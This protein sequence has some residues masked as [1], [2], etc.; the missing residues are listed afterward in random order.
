MKRRGIRS[1]LAWFL[2]VALLLSIVPMAVYA[3]EEPALRSL[4]E[5]KTGT[6]TEEETEALIKAVV[7]QLTLTEKVDLLGGT[8]GNAN[9]G[10]RIKNTGAAGGTYTSARLKEMGI[11]PLTLSDGPAG[12]RM[13]YKA[14][15][16]TSPTA[17]ASTWDKQAMHDIAV[18]TGKEAVFYGIDLMLAPGQNILR[19]PVAG[20]NFEYYSEDPFVSGTNALEYTKGV[21][22]QGVGVTL[23]HYAGNEQES[24]R[25]GGNTIISERALRE[26][27]LKGFEI[28]VRGG[29]P[30]SVMGSYNRL[31]NIYAC[32]NTWLMTDVLRGDWGFDGF[33]MSDWGAASDGRQALLAQMDLVES[34]MNATQKT[35][36]RNTITANESGTPDATYP[37]L[38]MALLDRNVT[39]IL[40]GVTRSNIFR[41]KYGTWGTAIDLVQTEQNFYASELFAESNAL[42][43][44]TSADAM[45]LLKNEDVLPL[46]AEAGMSLLL[47]ANLK[48]RGGFGDNGVTAT[49]IV[50]RGGGSAGVYF[51]PTHA[52]VVSLESALQES[53]FK[54]H[55]PV[56]DINQAAGQTKSLS[57]GRQSNRVTSITLNYSGT[58]N[59]STLATSTAALA[60]SDAAYGLM[61]ISRQTGEGSDNSFTGNDSYYLT[62]NEEKALNAYAQALHAAGKKLVVILNV[63]AAIDTT[64]ITPVADAILVSWLAGQEGGHAV[65]DVLSGAVNPSGKLTQTFTKS[66]ADS[67]S[68]AAALALKEQGVARSPNAYS[69]TDTNGGFGT[70]PVF[71]DEGVLV[72]Y[73]WFDTKLATKEEYDAKVAYP[74]GFGL[75][76]TTFAFSNLRL[77]RDIFNSKNPEDTIK[78]T[79]AVKNTGLVK[80]KETVQLYL[81]ADSCA[82]EGR[83]MKDLR[84][85]AKVELAPDETKDVTFTIRLS[86]LQYFDDGQ[87][88]DK[89]LAGASTGGSNVT[90]GEG[91]GWTVAEGTTF[92]VIIGDTSNNFELAERGVKASFTYEP[93]RTFK[94]VA[95]VEEYGA[96]VPAVI[97]DMGES[98]AAGGFDADSF[99]VTMNRLTNAT[100]VNPTPANRTIVK[101]YVND[102]EEID[103]SGVGTASGRYIVLELAYGYNDVNYSY[104][105]QYIFGG[106]VAHNIV[107]PLELYTVRQTAAIQ[108]GEAA[109]AADTRYVNMGRINLIV[110]DFSRETTNDGLNYRLFTPEKEAEKTYPL[111]VWLH[112][113]GEGH[114]PANFGVGNEEQ[115]LGNEGATAW[116]EPARQA[117]NPSYVAAPQS[118]TTWARA[119]AAKIKRMIDEI[120]ATH[121]DVDPARIYVTGCSMGGMMTMSM[122]TAYPNL[123]AAA[124]PICAATTVAS[125]AFTTADYAKLA[126]LPMW[127]FHA[128]NDPTV[129]I[130]QSSDL[131]YAT[132]QGLGKEPGDDFKYTIF[133][134]VDYNQHWAW[135]PVANDS[136]GGETLGVVDWLFAQVRGE[137]TLGIVPVTGGLI[138]G[139]ASDTAGVTIYKG[140][141]FAKPPVGELRWKAPQDLD[142]V[143]WGNAVRICDTWGSQAYQNPDLNPPGGF[144]GDEFYYEGSPRPAVSEDCLYLNVYTPAQNGDEKLPVLVWIHGGG[145]DHGFASEVEFNASKLAAKGIIVVSIQYRVGVFGYLSLPGLS[146][147]DPNGV[148]GNYGLLDQIKSLEWVKNNITAFG[149]DPNRVTVSGQSAGGMS[150]RGLLSSPLAKGLFKRA[151]LQ[152]GFSGYHAA[153]SYPT[154]VTTQEAMATRMQTQFGTADV[155]AL[156]QIDAATLLAKQGQLNVG[157]MVLDGHVLTQES[158]DL[159]RP[160]VFDG[161]DIV[162]GG[163]SDEY[164]SLFGNPSG[165]TNRSAFQNNMANR[166]G[167]YY[168]ED[169]YDAQTDKDAYRMN[170]RSNADG[171]LAQY[172]L[173]AMY[174]NLHN[175]DHRAYVYYFEHQLPPHSQEVVGDR[176][177][178]FY[179]AFHSSELWYMFNSMRT[180]PKQRQW[181]EA[182]Y[183]LGELMSSY[184][185]NFVKT[186]DPN[187]E[188]LPLWRTADAA[189]GGEFMSFRLGEAFPDGSEFPRRDFVNLVYA[190]NSL[191]QMSDETLG[192]D[193][194]TVSVLTSEVLAGIER[195]LSVAVTAAGGASVQGAEVMLTD[196]RTVYGRGVTG[197]G[198]QAV[199]HHEEL[200][201]VGT[202]YVTARS[203]IL[204]AAAEVPVLEKVRAFKVVTRVEEYGAVVPAVIIDMGESVAAGDAYADAFAV[205]LNQLDM[206]TGGVNPTPV[207]R[208][209]AKAYV[210]D[211][212][213][214]DPA[215]VGTASG[216]YIVLELPYGYNDANYSYVMQYMFNFT[217]FMASHNVVRPL[218]MYAVQQTAAIQNGETAIAADT[219]YVNAGRINL[220][221]DD[222]SRET[223]D[224]GLSYRLFTPEKEEGKTYPLIVWLH[225]A[226]E[227][228][229]Q[230][231]F[232]VG[233]EEQLLG[234]EGATAWAEPARQA[235]N[236]SYVAAPQA[237][238]VWERMDAAKIKAMIDEILAAHPDVDTARIYVTGCSMGGMMTMS[239]ITAYPNLFAAAIPICAATM[240]A[241]PAF[242]TADYAKLTDLPMWLFHAQT[243]PTV[244][245]AQSSDLI[246]ATLQE[247]GKEPGD[248]LKYTIFPTVE[249]NGHWSW[250]PVAND[251]YDGETLGVVD[252][253]FAQVETGDFTVTADKAEKIVTITGRNYVPGWELPLLAAY[254]RTPTMDDADYETTVTVDEDGRFSVTVPADVT[255][256]KSWLGGHEYVVTVGGVT[257]IA[258]IYT[259][260]LRAH[261]SARISL[262][263]KGKAPLNLLT[264]ADPAFYEVTVS[265]PAVARVTET[266]G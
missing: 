89:V 160:G 254:N 220:I 181:T 153:S 113:A 137:R 24:S 42:A 17:I 116:A 50:A 47:S 69:G 77:S 168:E 141:P 233:N 59:D 149:G 239:M 18:Q 40:R 133:P 154:L 107:R 123:F 136:Y 177:E 262:R 146:A 105:M 147:E 15:T 225:G 195:D 88:Q 62:A 178:A 118:P 134:T 236:P 163:T 95:R 211:R 12:V 245:I 114:N 166:F 205:T 210:N 158:V 162:I 57:Y 117:Q 200:P 26:I 99:A 2:A 256:D 85:Y 172:R 238:L 266:D 253:L 30:M 174:S 65:A 102:K 244:P 260:V 81:G 13:G 76:Y 232:G 110:D 120:L 124:M 101:A 78:A 132:L 119:D 82:A 35:N 212:E 148:S 227:G 4:E 242:T 115:L 20:R 257:H 21:Q 170:L 203:G 127:L 191:Y 159:S 240:V 94:V 93:A 182:D 202:Y 161:L 122:I 96:V 231:D 186:G 79:V 241:D 70:N 207:A 22:S 72:G 63:G 33:V 213:E 173:S 143:V 19:N 53:G 142:A 34:S 83:P 92:D 264:D 208:A 157:N 11:P 196:G 183:R 255:A 14:T 16:W 184:W 1:S 222:F 139:V 112:G 209:I 55:G 130:A 164:T 68:V 248:D 258:P 140:V 54:I 23:K 151:I 128:Q 100:T 175:E 247:L 7:S 90:Y 176:D 44:R 251:S 221:V 52:S 126:D 198:G 58:F 259:T 235:Q 80:G 249:Y 188:E 144:W 228:H 223:T 224:D 145:F 129:R 73:R 86:D 36:I 64:K 8:S 229:S 43:R 215:G 125:P 169:I 194:L 187:G 109:I 45:V 189:S 217:N 74:F 104:V 38:T 261:S 165:T 37:Q 49:D 103:P 252:W 25:S 155:A 214:I 197:T 41:D 66:F 28:A 218:E 131:I 48:G 98:V 75:S 226:G 237:V 263:I 27:Y 51:D 32:Y 111:I 97:I 167:P 84:D 219:R 60:A 6:W 156:R 206:F 190:K 108:S 230:T 152:S 56:Q 150:V 67:P 61:V 71:Y 3:A 10:T 185:A 204:G 199:I 192:L 46:P 171:I 243:D 250:V 234:N 39:N 106:A 138:R 246:Y 31:N 91:D 135:V 265:N 193:T 5:L 216:R 9:A 29:K 121:P 87:N 201:D 180:D 179:H